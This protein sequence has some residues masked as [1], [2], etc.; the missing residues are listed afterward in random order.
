MR[1]HY[2]SIRDIAIHPMLLLVAS[3]SE[4]GTSGLTDISYSLKSF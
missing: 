1:E 3:V 4:D 2:G